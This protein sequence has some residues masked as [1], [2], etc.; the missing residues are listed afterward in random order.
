MKWFYD[1]P[2]NFFHSLKV[3]VNAFENRY[4]NQTS[5][6]C[7]T[8]AM[9]K[10]ESDPVKGPTIIEKFQENAP[11]RSLPYCRHC[12]HFHDGSTCIVARR[13]LDS[14]KVGPED[15]INKDMQFNQA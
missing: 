13:I 6:P 15:Q 14:G 11:H 12:E 7:T 2:N 4:G 8:S 9:K 3:I 5:S 1:F 10:D